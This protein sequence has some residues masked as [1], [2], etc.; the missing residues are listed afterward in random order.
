MASFLN[1]AGYQ[2]ISL[3]DIECL[4]VSFLEKCTR[5]DL[6]GTI[7]L[8]AEGVNFNL[9]GLP[10]LIN[11]FK[12]ELKKD[13][14]FSEISFRESVSSFQP[15]RYMRVKLKKEIITMGRPEVRPDLAK[16]P[17][18]SPRDFK[19][20]LDEK[21][22]ITVLDTRNDYE[23]RFGA[24]DTATHFQLND[25]SEFPK[26]IHALDK[27]QTIVMYC[28]GGI[29]CE[30]AAL[31]LLN[32]GF[33]QVYQLSGGILNYFTEVGGEHYH[34]ECFVF[35]ER[36]SVNTCLEETG[37]QQCIA[38]QGPVTREQQKCAEYVPGVSCP[39]CV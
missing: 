39:V 24:F 35:D 1:I 27:H 11:T 34:G 5:L 33:D 36:V 14:R 6:K 26:A 18:L 37:T 19:Q 31:H 2:F 28:T 12:N 9:V 21:R 10:H 25:F 22:E 8:S 4:R 38:C 29:R 23:V 13:A 7:L 16:A 32:E 15:F 17:S 3:E 30:K 20:W